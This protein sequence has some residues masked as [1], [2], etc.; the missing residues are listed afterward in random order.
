MH[1]GPPWT[2]AFKHCPPS[3]NQ[4]PVFLLCP[5][6]CF[7]YMSVQYKKKKKKDLLSA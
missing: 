7:L 6:F 3:L 2:L 1:I 4:V 5:L